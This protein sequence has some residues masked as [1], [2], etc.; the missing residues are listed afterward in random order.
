MGTKKILVINPN[1]SKS[2]T[3]LLAKMIR[4]LN[5]IL[6]FSTEVSTY[7]APSGP[8]SI[9]NDDDALASA[10]IVIKDLK[11]RL[12][13]YD[14]FLV[15]CYSK[16]P[17]VEMLKNEVGR[18]NIHVLGILEASIL[19]ALSMLPF[20]EGTPSKNYAKFGI[21]TTGSY[22]EQSLKDAVGLFLDARGYPS[23][24]FGGR[25]SR[26]QSTGLNADELHTSPQE[27]VK[28]KL[29]KA[30]RALLE[31]DEAIEVICLG[32]AG[33]VG[34]EDIVREAWEEVYPTKRGSVCIV[35]GVKSG[36][37]MLES[38]I[39]AFPRKE[40]KE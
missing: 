22:W 25:F 33:M 13:N 27:E 23:G 15:A 10:H 1:S 4:E 20:V 30:A 21:I 7:T 29:K 3:G 8:P 34:L 17:L 18:L 36:I 37:G 38:M 32:C 14:G 19:T 12:L 11:P 5:G 6:P 24:D 16:H 31:N 35:D 39:R 2:M 9:N 26:V 40:S 28:K